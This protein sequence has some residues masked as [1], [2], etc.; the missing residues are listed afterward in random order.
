M[1]VLHVSYHYILMFA[2]FDKTRPN[3]ICLKHFQEDI[4]TAKTK[5]GNIFKSNAYLRICTLV[6]FLC[7]DLDVKTFHA[8]LHVYHCYNHYSSH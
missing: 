5:Q 6:L 3:L 4:G 7:W 1:C 2:Y 8:D